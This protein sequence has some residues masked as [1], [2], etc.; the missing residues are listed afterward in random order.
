[1]SK[2]KAYDPQQGY[3]YQIFI[4]SPY[5]RELEGLDYAKDYQDLKY[6]LN[7]YRLAYRGQSVGF[8]YTKLPRKYWKEA[9]E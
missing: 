9:I 1:M 5:E 8:S 3:Q 7:E 4:K 2:P 6:L